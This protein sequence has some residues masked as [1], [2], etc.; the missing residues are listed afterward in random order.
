MVLLAGGVEAQTT[1]PQTADPHAV[2]VV[3]GDAGP[4]S[5]VFTVTTGKGAPIYNAK[6][7]VHVAYGFLGMRKLDLEVGTNVDG[8]ARFQGLPRRLDHALHFLGS[9]DDLEGSAF[10][11][12]TSECDAMHRIVLLKQDTEGNQP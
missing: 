4:C 11:D 1:K 7:K 8:K 3:D 6:L 2:P 12:P 5:V 9:K 10:Y